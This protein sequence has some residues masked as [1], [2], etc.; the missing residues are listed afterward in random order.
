MIAGGGAFAAFDPIGSD[1]DVDACFERRSGDL[2][3]LKGKRCGRG[4][5]PVSWSQVGPRGP[6]GPPGAPGEQ[7][8]QGLAGAGAI[9]AMMGSA[10]TPLVGATNSNTLA[11]VGESEPLTG[12]GVRDMHGPNEAFRATDLYV[13]V[14]TAPGAGNT[15]EF[16]LQ[17]AVVNDQLTCSIT[18]SDNICDS[19]EQVVQVPAGGSFYFVAIP[20]SGPPNTGVDFGWRAIP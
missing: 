13:R 8:I 1:G 4:E 15:W 9:N 5:K 11:P 2:D 10:A 3:L 7:G 20:S 6:E 12:G 17:S 19:G 16:W 14:G 18:G